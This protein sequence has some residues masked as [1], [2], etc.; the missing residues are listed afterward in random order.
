MHFLN[1]AQAQN[2]RI[3]R[4]TQSARITNSNHRFDRILKI[5]HSGSNIDANEGRKWPRNIW[6]I[7]PFLNKKKTSNLKFTWI[8]APVEEIRCCLA[9]RR[10]E[11]ESNPKTEHG[12]RQG[13][14]WRTDEASTLQGKRCAP[15]MRTSTF[16]MTK[17]NLKIHV[18]S[19]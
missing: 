9:K 16:L 14:N 10:C 18:A 8:L 6:R 4:Q 7:P 13:R 3:N 19:Y 1:G 2:S 11:M 12:R 15:V 17:V 5:Q